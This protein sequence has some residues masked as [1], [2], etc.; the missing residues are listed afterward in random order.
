VSSVPEADIPDVLVRLA[1]EATCLGR[2][3]H[4]SVSTATVYVQLAE[5]LK[6]L[7]RLDEV[8]R[9]SDE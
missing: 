5:F 2:M 6:Q 8:L 7:D 9:A 1:R 4:Q 3:P